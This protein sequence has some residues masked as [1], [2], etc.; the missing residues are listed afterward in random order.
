MLYCLD[1]HCQQCGPIWDRV[2]DG[3]TTEPDVRPLLASLKSGFKFN[4]V[5]GENSSKSDVVATPQS[6]PAVDQNF[7][8]KLDYQNLPRTILADLVRQ[9]CGL[10]VL[11]E[12]ERAKSHPAFPDFIIYM[13]EHYQLPDHYVWGLPVDDPLE[14]LADFVK[15]LLISGHGEYAP[16]TS[17]E[18][19]ETSVDSR[20]RLPINKK[21]SCIF[22]CNRTLCVKLG[23][24]G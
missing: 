23:V 10:N 9:D 12:N 17:I 18:M 16:K 11:G 20:M 19:P 22:V 21:E 1:P 2:R 4:T 6:I 15:W 5:G 13:K 14:D 3:I 8:N 24:S 7:P